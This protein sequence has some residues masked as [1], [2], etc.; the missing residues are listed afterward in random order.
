MVKFAEL[1]QGDKIKLEGKEYIVKNIEVSALG[2]HGH[3]KCRLE[4]ENNE[5]KEN[6]VVIKPAE[7]EVL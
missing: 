1:K 5:T 3:R 4:L 2:K 6:E 7:E